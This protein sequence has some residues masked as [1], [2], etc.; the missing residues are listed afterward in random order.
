MPG[1]APLLTRRPEWTALAEHCAKI[2]NGDLRT[3][4]A[5][6]ADAW[7]ESQGMPTRIAEPLAFAV[8]IVTITYFSV[9][10]GELVPKQIGMLNAERIA[11]RV[12]AACSCRWGEW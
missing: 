7:L 3:L 8:V 1:N 11:T 12:A 5:E 6:R 10:A 9:V 2:K 4:F